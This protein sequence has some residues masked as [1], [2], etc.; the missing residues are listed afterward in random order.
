M[1]ST[2]QHNNSKRSQWRGSPGKYKPLE[3]VALVR[4]PCDLETDLDALLQI[5]NSGKPCEAATDC[6]KTCSESR[7][8]IEPGVFP[9]TI[10]A[11]S[12]I[13]VALHAVG[14][15]DGPPDIGA[16]LYVTSYFR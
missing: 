14:G 16:R 1:L 10:R 4:S 8:K 3:E 11:M 6:M 7:V 2:V 5:D 13:P 12:T 15:Y 9:L